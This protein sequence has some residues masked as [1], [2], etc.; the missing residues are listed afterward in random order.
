MEANS[1]SVPVASSLQ[2]CTNVTK[3]KLSSKEDYTSWYDKGLEAVS[4][5]SLGVLI[6]AGGQ[7]TRLGSSKPKGEY[8]ILLPSHKSLFQLQCERI[9]KVR[10]LASASFN[11]PLENIH[12]PLYVMTSPMTDAET[13]EFFQQ[14]ANFGLESGDVHFFSQGT[15]PCLDFNGK[16]ILESK[17]SVASAPDGNGGLYRALHLSGMVANMRSRNLIGLHVFAV[18]NAIVRV[19]DPVFLGYCLKTNADVGNKVCPKSSPHEAVGVLCLKDNKYSVVEYSEMDKH[20]AE[21]RD[22]DTHE[23]VFNAGNICIHYFSVDFLANKCSPSTL[24]KIYHLAKKA[25]PFADPKDGHTLTKE[26]MAG[27]GNTGIKLESFIFD[28]FPASEHLSALEIN[29]ENEFS[30][31]KN[32]PGSTTDS[33]D[34]A[35]KMISVLHSK[36]L[37]EHQVTVVNASETNLV[38]VSPLVSYGGEGLDRL[39]GSELTAPLLLASSSEPVPGTD[40]ITYS[41]AASGLRVPSHPREDGVMVYRL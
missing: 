26:E 36:W 10:A 20:S 32:A 25:I 8:D 24:P 16:I 29:R 31:V 33:P 34:T 23:L 35:R 27:K 11:V 4:T 38:E 5:S 41:V 2:P 14:H 1:S 6:L 40:G 7:G 13:R 17:T 28:V 15:L 30:P 12:L 39:T 18:D 37:S 22:P 21:L 3:L 19:A 9:T